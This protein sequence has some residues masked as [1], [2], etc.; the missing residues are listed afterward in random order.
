MGLDL[1]CA[2]AVIGHAVADPTIA[3]TKS[4][5]RI[6]FPKAQ[7]HANYA[8]TAGYAV[9]LQAQWLSLSNPAKSAFPKQKGI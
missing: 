9:L 4:R 8:I 6:A 3:L 7:D 1:L 2:C 5:R